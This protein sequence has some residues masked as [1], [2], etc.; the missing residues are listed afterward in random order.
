M[1]K[2]T[3]R[4]T[5][6]QRVT[7]ALALMEAL[8]ASPDA[9]LTIE[10]ACR[11][12]GCG[13]A[14]LDSI[15]DLISTLADREGG[16]RAIVVREQGCVRSYG[17]A[18]H[19][20]PLRLSA[21]EAAA[22]D[23]VLDTLDIDDDVRE[24]IA[25]ALLPFGWREPSTRLIATTTAYGACYQLLAEAVRD[26]VRCRMRYRS[27]G[28]R[29]A[30]ERIIDPL[31]IESTASGAYLIAWD[32]DHDEQRRYRMERIEAVALTD[33][34]VKH[35]ALRTTSMR[36]SLAHGGETVTISFDEQGPIPVSSW[37]GVER[38][39]ADPAH[40]GRLLAQMH[41]TAR[42]WFFD[43]VLASRGTITIEGPDEVRRACGAYARDLLA[44]PRPSCA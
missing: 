1:A 22:L 32:V 37:A 24:R 41:V 12:A 16:T 9:R 43:Q 38:I 26:G 10:D 28:E 19:M 20:L 35:H 42:S 33:D 6:Q 17:T 2:S 29:T 11:V 44:E 36:E 4:L 39:E 23:H 3:K 25:R 18:T 21:A 40:A 15:I 31:D 8:S 14:D 34:S 7:G 27:Q 13:D 30:R 5:E